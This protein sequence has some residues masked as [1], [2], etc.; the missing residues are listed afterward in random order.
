VIKSLSIESDDPTAPNEWNLTTT[1]T[2]IER[3]AAHTEVLSRGVH[4]EPTRLDDRSCNDVSRFHGGTP[5][6]AEGVVGRGD[7]LPPL[8][9][10]DRNVRAALGISGSCD[11][12]GLSAVANLESARS[13]GLARGNLAAETA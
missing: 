5:S 8:A 1:D 9:G 6:G 3:M 13:S 11:R 4:V 12:Q 10:T 7:R 2:V